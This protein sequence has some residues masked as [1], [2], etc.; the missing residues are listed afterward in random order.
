MAFHKFKSNTE[1]AEVWAP[2]IQSWP[3]LHRETVSQQTIL[4]NTH[5]VF[6]FFEFVIILCDVMVADIGDIVF[7]FKFNLPGH[8]KEYPIL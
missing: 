5:A 3:R 4:Q 1:K 7:K 2:W 8:G 6:F